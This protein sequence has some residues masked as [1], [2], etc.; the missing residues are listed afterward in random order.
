MAM[1]VYKDSYSKRGESLWCT[2]TKVNLD[3]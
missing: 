3:L 1:V 2:H